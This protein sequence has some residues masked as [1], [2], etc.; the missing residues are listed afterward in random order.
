[1]R[2]W[3][4]ACLVMYALIFSGNSNARQQN[5]EDKFIEKLT[6]YEPNLLGYSWDSDDEEPFLDF[7]ISLKYPLAYSFTKGLCDNDIIVKCIPFLAFTGRFGQ[8][9]SVRESSPVIDKRFNP[10]VFM[11]FHLD[12]PNNRKVKGYKLKKEYIDVYYGHESNGQRINSLRSWQSLRNDFE[13]NNEHVYYANDYI[14]R[15]WDYWGATYKF[16]SDDKFY[17]VYLNYKNFIGGILQGEVEERFQW[18]DNREISSRKQVDGLGFTVKYD[19]QNR[20]NRT[21]LKGLTI[22]MI[23]NTGIRDTFEYNTVK[24]EF[25]STIYDMPLMLW[26]KHGY[27]ADFA[28]FY[29]QTN[30]VGLA[31]EFKSF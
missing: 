26:F 19:N 11:R 17:H 8:Y 20:F 22:A 2:C 12:K 4:L 30:S 29:K 5:N 15:G 13:D 18:E 3:N 7:K 27:N 24:F 6:S 10:S 31:F 28:Q 9:I 14:S 16:T 23:Y 1:M 25:T 21:W